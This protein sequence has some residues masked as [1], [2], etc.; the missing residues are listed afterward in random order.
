MQKFREKYG[1][2]EELDR[3]VEVYSSNPAKKERKKQYYIDNK[4]SIKETRKKR[5]DKIAAEKQ[6][7]MLPE[8]YKHHKG[9]LE[10]YQNSKDDKDF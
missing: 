10:S 7:E 8:T 3:Q 1:S 4:E 9:L 2:G 6:A 5:K